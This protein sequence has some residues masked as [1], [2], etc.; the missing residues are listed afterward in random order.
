APVFQSVTATATA[1][2]GYS[3]TTNS[4]NYFVAQTPEN[5]MYDLDGNLTVDGHW[6]Y[7]YDAENRLIALVAN[8]SL[9]TVAR[10]T[11]TNTYDAIGRR[12]QKSVWRWSGSAY[13]NQYTRRFLYDGWNL[14]SE[15]DGSNNSI[16][17]YIWGLDLSGTMQ[18]AGGVGGLLVVKPTGS[19]PLF[20]AY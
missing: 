15:L 5:Y 12:V 13:T 9:P 14:V 19:N 18:G 8:T 3:A 20:V 11:I 10:C 16:R 17:S 2:G 1:P 7:T 4:G 6:T